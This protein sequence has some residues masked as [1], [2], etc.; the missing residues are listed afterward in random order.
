MNRVLASRFIQSRD[1]PYLKFLD[2][3]EIR[4]QTDPRPDLLTDP[5]ENK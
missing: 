5:T 3:E 2:P 4:I 1:A